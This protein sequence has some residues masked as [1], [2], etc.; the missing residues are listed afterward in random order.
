MIVDVRRSIPIATTTGR[1]CTPTV[2]EKHPAIMERT[3]S[4]ARRV[5]TPPAPHHGE[6]QPFSPRR[7]SR[8]AQRSIHLHREQ[9]IARTRRD[10]TPTST[11]RPTTRTLTFDLSPPTSPISPPKHRSPRTTRRVHQDAGALDSVSQPKATC[12]SSVGRFYCRA[13]DSKHVVAH[14]DSY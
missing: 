11:A 14:V 2:K 7:S 9:T 8:V 6:W 13:H 10:V 4:P 1:N 5:H 3:P 12:L